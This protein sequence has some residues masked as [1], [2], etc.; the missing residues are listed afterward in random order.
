MVSYSQRGLSYIPSEIKELAALRSLPEKASLSAV[1]ARTRTLA[2]TQS[3]PNPISPPS[4]SSRSFARSASGSL[5]PSP[6]STA[7]KTAVALEFNFSNNDLCADSFPNAFFTLSNLRVLFLRQNHLERLPEGIGRLADL[8]ELSVSNNQLTYIP[9]EILR[10]SNLSQ[11]RLHPNPFLSP[12]STSSSPSSKRL[13]GP[14]KV[15][16][17]VPSLF[18]SMTR[19]LLAPA[20]SKASLLPSSTDS[21][22]PL[23]IQGYE[24]PFDL[25]DTVFAPFKSIMPLPPSSNLSHAASRARERTTSVG[26]T[27]S[28]FNPSPPVLAAPGPQPFDPS[29]N[30]CYS[31]AHAGE[32]RHFYQPAVE[33]FEWVS[34]SSL[35]S[36]RVDSGPKKIPLRHRGCGATCLDWLEEEE[37]EMSSEGEVT[38]EE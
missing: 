8:V 30:V 10:L 11:L 18:E 16:F 24:L 4:S 7:P 31:P 5:P 21:T 23:T 2:R 12:P 35:K 26:S 37:E 32:G 9:A 1:P 17:T 38:E 34:E 15:N 25:S 6:S 33:R 13:L 22:P 3:V 14:L 36:G 19:K 29:S 27:R 20:S 28:L